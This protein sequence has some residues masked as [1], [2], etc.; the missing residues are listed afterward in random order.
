M[1]PSL[2]SISQQLQPQAPPTATTEQWHASDAQIGVIARDVLARGSKP[3]ASDDYNVRMAYFAQ[4]MARLDSDSRARLF[5]EVL[6]KDRSWLTPERVNALVSDSKISNAQRGAIADGFAAAYNEKLLGQVPA[7]RFLNPNF[8]GASWEAYQGKVN[9]ISDFLNSAK[10][11]D[12]SKFARDF[13]GTLL[14]TRV[15]NNNYGTFADR[16]PATFALHLLDGVGTAQDVARTYASFNQAGRAKILEAL[17]YDGRGL[18]GIN[19]LR[20]WSRTDDPFAILT[21]AIAQQPG[22]GQ[23]IVAGNP[24]VGMQSTP[25]EYDKR[26]LEIVQFAARSNDYN[27]YMG[28]TP[29][30][31]RAE[32][33]ADLFTAHDDYILRE[34]TDPQP[35][36]EMRGSQHV[37]VSVETNKVLGN[38]FC[39]TYLNPKLSTSKANAMKSQITDYAN[40]LTKGGDG[41]DGISNTSRLGM[42]LLGLQVGVKQ[43][44]KALEDYRAAQERL[45]SFFSGLAIGMAAKG[46]G[47]ATPKGIVASALADKAISL[48]TTEGKNAAAQALTDFV[49]GKYDTKRADGIQAA[50][51]DLVNSYVVGLDDVAETALNAYLI[52]NAIALNDTG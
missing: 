12:A 4:Q 40:T 43:N 14:E 15:V 18:D 37:P 9:A 48:G 52:A 31:D 25:T 47:K 45:I 42:L 10:S 11:P 20:G 34:L 17:A 30:D 2:G 49:F 1:I 29:L 38:L 44:Y 39:M 22:Q 27:F 51:N 26:A 33:M 19:D 50:V 5:V 8:N 28:T 32:A 7:I 6:K 35:G 24:G 13:A 46:V 3:R 21:T 16:G 41:R 36:R 23:P